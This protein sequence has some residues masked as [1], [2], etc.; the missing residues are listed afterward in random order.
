MLPQG[1]AKSV[2]WDGEGATCLLE[3]V[4]AGGAWVAAW[5]ST[6]AGQH[7]TPCKHAFAAT[8]AL[9]PGARCGAAHLHIVC[10]HVMHVPSHQI[11]LYLIE[12]KRNVLCCRCC[13]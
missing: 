12:A 11:L 7:L 2:A 6:A 13:R 1:L 10:R 3:V 4:C 9:D 5:A 8:T